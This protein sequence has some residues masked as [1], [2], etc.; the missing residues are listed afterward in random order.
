[1]TDVEAAV[2][3]ARRAFDETKWSEDHAFRGRCISQLREALQRHADELRE[4]P[5]R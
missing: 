2:G 4:I 5:V 1:V 3:A